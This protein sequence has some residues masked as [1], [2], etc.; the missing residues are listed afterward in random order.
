MSIKGCLHN[1][2]WCGLLNNKTLANEHPF[3]FKIWFLLWWGTMISLANSFDFRSFLTPWLSSK[4]WWSSCIFHSMI[5]MPH[6]SPFLLE[7]WVW[8]W[9]QHNPPNHVRI[10]HC[11]LL[12]HLSCVRS[13][14]GKN[15]NNLLNQE[16]GRLESKLRVYFYMHAI[17]QKGVKEQ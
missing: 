16:K 9:S 13:S 15:R 2:T 5:L 10:R 14:K 6:C 17:K 11:F 1:H 4:I 3:E 7:P 8:A 12:K